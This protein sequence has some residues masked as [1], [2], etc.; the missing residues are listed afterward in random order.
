M[1]RAFSHVISS[2]AGGGNP[3]VSFGTPADTAVARWKTNA[4]T[5]LQ[6]GNVYITDAGF[7]GIGTAA[8][9]R[10]LTITASSGAVGVRIANTAIET[11]GF[12][13]YHGGAGADAFQI[14]SETNAKGWLQLLNSSGFIGIGGD[15]LTPVVNLHIDRNDSAYIKFSVSGTTGSGVGD[16]FN[17][18]VSSGGVA[19]LIQYENAG[20]DIYT[21]NALALS[22]TA[23]GTLYF[24]VAA[25]ETTGAGS[26]ALGA[27][28]PAVTASAPFK[29]IT[30]ALSDGS[31][32]FVPAWK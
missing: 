19:Q 11:G 12:L 20:I 5:T 10:I 4:A 22:L 2:S 16:G 14:Y 31:T 7:M 3:L 24:R 17:I 23:G 6:G 29:W 21:N 30:M 28:C 13:L 8:P 25:N 15:A 32:V 18:G 27:N 9:N 1:S 26:A